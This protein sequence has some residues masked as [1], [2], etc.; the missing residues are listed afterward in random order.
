MLHAG[1]SRCREHGGCQEEEGEPH[2]HLDDGGLGFSGA[3]LGKLQG[4]LVQPLLRGYEQS[5]RGSAA[6]LLVQ[7][8]LPRQQAALQARASEVHEILYDKSSGDYVC[9]PLT[10]HIQRNTAVSPQRRSAV[11]LFGR[12]NTLRNSPVRLSRPNNAKPED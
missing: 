4:E 1:R 8:R 6:S 10:M 9:Q 5:G 7:M 11:L 3:L 12:T 2:V